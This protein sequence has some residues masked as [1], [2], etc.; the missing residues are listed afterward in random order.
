MEIL[1]IA[2][3][4]FGGAI[5]SLPLVLIFMFFT[6][7]ERFV[8]KWGWVTLFIL[9]MNA[10]LIIIGMPAARYVVWSPTINWIPFNDFTFSNIIGMIL[11]VVLF[12]PF[13]GFLPIYFKK[14]RKVQNTVI[15]GFLMSLFIEVLQLFTFRATD[16]DDLLMNTIGALAGYGIARLIIG[17]KESNE[18]NNKDILKLVAM[19]LIVILTIVL[20]RYPLVSFLFELFKF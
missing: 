15:A 7:R 10:T 1:R 6:D 14:F 16:V 17:K 2:L 4:W 11:N 9:Y 12:V 20:V 13:G 8:K 19:I 3:D 18:E 5:V